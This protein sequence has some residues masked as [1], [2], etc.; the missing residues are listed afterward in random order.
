MTNWLFIVPLAL[1]VL[2]IILGVGSVFFD[3]G[4]FFYDKVVDAVAIVKPL[5]EPRRSI[6]RKYFFYYNKLSKPD[7]K[8]FE[9]RVNRLL[10][11]KQFIGRGISI[12]EEMK[13]LISATAVLITFGLPMVTLANFDKI[14][15]YADTYYSHINHQYHLGEVNPRLGIITLSWKA[16]VEGFVD[17]H[18]A[19]NLALHEIAHALHFENQIRNEEYQ[20][21]NHDALAL[22]DELA[23]KEIVQINGNSDHVLRAY[24]GTN[25]HEFFA[26][27]IEYFFESSV[28][29]N[30]ALPELY[31]T[32]CKLLNQNPMVLYKL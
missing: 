5:S 10:H 20:F 9:E 2:M 14:L 24:A 29:F 25:E 23:A 16:F 6:L 27:A 17:N 12:T 21:L 32:M 1:L 31:D 30:Q 18:D 7:Q 22:W 11:S 3:I 28:E 19:R 4:R 13:V 26:V 8:K 15:I